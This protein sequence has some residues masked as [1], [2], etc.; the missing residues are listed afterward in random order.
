MLVDGSGVAKAFPDFTV[1][2]G[3][4]RQIVTTWDPPLLCICH[5]SVS[6]VAADGSVE[7]MTVR[8]IVFPLA[9]FGWVIGLLLVAFVGFRWARRA[10][11]STVLKAAHALP[12]PVSSGDA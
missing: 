6:V 9:L 5:P 1:L 3:A 7:T 11:R 2:R 12:R 10:Y 4:T 8:V